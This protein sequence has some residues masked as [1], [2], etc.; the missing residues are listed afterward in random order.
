MNVT[1]E[2]LRQRITAIATKVTRYQG[3]V[4]RYTQ[5]RLFEN[6][7][8]HF[9]RKFDQEEEKCIDDQPVA[10]ESKQF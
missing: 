3:R 5:N 1:I 9:Y 7:Q 8:R 10:E 4:D 2:E 6:N